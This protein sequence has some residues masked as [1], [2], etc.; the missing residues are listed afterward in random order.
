MQFHRSMSVNWRI[1]IKFILSLNV[2]LDI[3]SHGGRPVQPSN[4]FA[5][6]VIVGVFFRKKKIH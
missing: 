6:L 4:A 1:K 5:I 3:N 2:S